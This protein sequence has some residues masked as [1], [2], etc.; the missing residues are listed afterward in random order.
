[1]A[2]QPCDCL[3]LLRPDRSLLSQ[4]PDMD[5]KTRRALIM[6]K[7]LEFFE[8]LDKEDLECFLKNVNDL[9]A[10]K[11][12]I[13]SVTNKPLKPRG[14]PRKD[15]KPPIQRKHPELNFPDTKL[16]LSKPISNK[17]S[18][19]FTPFTRPVEKPTVSSKEMDATLKRI[20]AN[21]PKNIL[22]EVKRQKA[23][24]E[25][26]IKKQR[27][28]Y[29]EYRRKKQRDYNRKHNAHYK[30]YLENEERYFPLYLSGLVHC[31]GE[32]ESNFGRPRTKLSDYLFALIYTV[33]SQKSSRR[34]MGLLRYMVNEG[35]LTH[36]PASNSTTRF[37][38]DVK[39]EEILRVLHAISATAVSHLEVTMMIDSSGFQTTSFNDWFSEKH[40][41]KK[42]HE[43]LKM[44]ACVGLNTR[45]IAA[46]TVT[47]KN[48]HDNTQFRPL[49]DDV[50]KCFDVLEVVADKAYDARANYELTSKYKIR[51]L[52]PFRSTDTAKGKGVSEWT[53]AFLFMKENREEFDALYHRRSNVESTF[54]SIK[55]QLGEHIR[56][57]K[58]EAQ[59]N[60]LYCKAIAY[61]IKTLIR[62][63]YT[64]DL[65]PNFVG[66]EGWEEE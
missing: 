14:R 5:E 8:N 58:P 33:Y 63:R 40:N 6:A 28:E 3:D 62:L 65:I 48:S 56:S 30:R 27:E 31:L 2:L 51:L 16:P 45:I 1:M 19:D 17:S 9:F 10:I 11:E 22:D 4:E 43:W 34:S 12:E 47:N 13:R 50:V 29:Y 7:G 44:H 35:Y 59:K 41:V 66:D 23:E 18:S 32:Q 42:E 57:K 37:L 54:H 49:I 64:N 38:A 61:N 21:N 20:A 39:T 36:I 25:Y 60:E 55:S 26:H 52:V 53:D 15:G 46:V 24:R